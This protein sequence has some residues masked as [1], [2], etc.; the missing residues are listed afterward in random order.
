MAHLMRKSIGS[1][2][3]LYVLSG[4]LVG[5]SS[6]SY[7]FYQVLEH[8]AKDQIQGT[9]DTQVK[10]IESELGQV[11]QSMRDLTAALQTVDQLGVEDAETYKQLAF[12]YFQNRSSLITGMGFGQAPFQ[13]AGDRQLYWPYFYRD[14]NSPDQVG[15]PLSAPHQDTRYVDVSQ[16]EDYSQLKYYQLPVS[17][18]TETW[19]EPF[20]WHGL[21]LTTLTTPVY[22]DRQQLL[23]VIGLDISVVALTAQI[24]AP[25]A[26][27]GGYM[28]IVSEQGNL[29]AYPPNPQWAKTLATYQNVPNLQ[30]V[31]QRIDVENTGILQ[32]GDTYWAYQRIE[33]THWLMLASV[34]RQV[35]IAPVLIIA[36]GSAI[37][38]G[39]ILALVVALFVRRLNQRLQP[40]LDECNK[41]A[42]TNLERAS[43]LNQADEILAS[44]RWKKL[45]RQNADE[46]DLLE[47]TFHQMTAQLKASFDELETRVAE[48]TIQLRQA[49]DTADAA[50]QAKSEFLANMSHE[51][52][53]PLNGILGYAQILQRS[54]TVTPQEQHGIQ[55][56]HQC[57]SHLLRLI[58]DILDLSKIEVG[59]LEL[60]PQAFHLP[61]FLQGIIEI[62]RIKIEQKQIQF[63]YYPPDDLPKGIVADEKRLRQVLVNL[64]GNAITVTDSGS[65]TLQVRVQ[66]L[67]SEPA[68]VRLHFSIQDMGIGIAA[69]SLDK[70]FL[71]FEQADKGKLQADGTGLELA[72]SQNIIEMMGSQITVS[73]ELGRGS[74]F[75]FAI[76][77]PLAHDWMQANTRTDLGQINGYVGKKRQILVVDDRWE[78]RSVIVD[79]LKP[80]GFEVIEACNGKEGLEQ[81]QAHHPDLVII[82]L[83]MPILDGLD[84]TRC[85]RQLDNLAK[86]PIIASSASVTE[87]DRYKSQLAGCDDFLP[88]PIQ[89]SDLLNFLKHYLDLEWVYQF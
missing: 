69:E 41:V 16:L 70:I 61:A 3:F 19:L 8:R 14:Q 9:L 48:R 31:W 12:R 35:V 46:I 32:A 27:R 39:G 47:H 60:H 84:T 26:W 36:V 34:P 63:V 77:C 54:Q 24:Q 30:K 74:S 56:I 68:T 40:I 42:A 88:K 21:T 86:T 13:L 18:G 22:D 79:L 23:G 28:A 11:Q 73:S 1:S 82:D 43:R 87:F 57:G 33:G 75:S 67:A 5:L 65:V 71:P 66:P 89:A 52:R 29:L 58:N 83:V 64:L 10:A 80:I 49:K 72:I 78:N 62:C 38:A 59:K 55:I 51:L 53:T 76:D 50:N 4:A 6:M 85:I 45:D 37:G 44:Q 15:Q 20:Q 81:L 2:L 7:C 25:K 17:T